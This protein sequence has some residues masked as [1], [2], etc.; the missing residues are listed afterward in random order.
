MSKKSHLEITLNPKYWILNSQTLRKT[1]S[2][3]NQTITMKI[4]NEYWLV[5]QSNTS[6]HCELVQPQRM[7]IHQFNH[8]LISYKLKYSTVPFRNRCQMMII[9]VTKRLGSVISQ[10]KQYSEKNK[11]IKNRY[12]SHAKKMME[13]RFFFVA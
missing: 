10:T 7:Q 6:V 3:E 8:L 2:I 9:M 13:I 4:L 5:K 11:E 1:G 12:K